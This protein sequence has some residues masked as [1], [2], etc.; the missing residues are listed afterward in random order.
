VQRS[1][2]IRNHFWIGFRAVQLKKV[3]VNTGDPT[4]TNNTHLRQ[5]LV[6][7]WERSNASPVLMDLHYG[8]GQATNDHGLQPG[9]TYSDTAGKTHVTNLG[10]GG[11]SPNEYIDVQVNTGKFLGN[12]APEPLW[13][14]LP[15]SWLVGEPLTMTVMPNDPDGDDVACNWLV[16][17]NS[18]AKNTSSNSVTHTW[19]SAAS[20][21]VKVNV[22]DMKG[23]VTKLSRTITVVNS[24]PVSQWSGTSSNDF[25]NTG[26]NWVAAAEPTSKIDIASWSDAFTGSNQPMISS[27]TPTRL[28][29]QLQLDP[30]L[31]KDVTLTLAET[32]NQLKVYHGGIDMSAADQNLRITGNGSVLLQTSQSWVTSAGTTLAVETDIDLNSK[33]LTVNSDGT[34]VLSCAIAGGQLRKTGSGLL[35]LEA[36]NSNIVNTVVDNGMLALGTASSIGTFSFAENL[37]LNGDLQLTIDPA[38]PQ[39]CD[40]ID[41]AGTLD[42]NGSGTI[43]INNI[44]GTGFTTGQLF[45]VFS[46]PFPGGATM[47]VS[48]AEPAPGFIW[49]NRLG[50]DGTIAVIPA[51]SVGTFDYWTVITS[52]V[53]GPNAGFE[54]DANGDGVKNGLAYF[55]GATTALDDATSLLPVWDYNPSNAAFIVSYPRLDEATNHI[56]SAIEYTTNLTEWILAVDGQDGI[57]ELV[58]DDYYAAGIDRVTVTLADILAPGGQLFGRLVVLDRMSPE[59]VLPHYGAWAKGLGLVGA[60]ADPS[61]D[62]DGDGLTN[63]EEFLGGTNP[64]DPPLP[65]GTVMYLSGLGGGF[66]GIIGDDGARYDPHS[67]LPSNFRVDG[68]RVGFRAR[69]IPGAVCVHMWGS[70]VEVLEIR[71]L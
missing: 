63:V 16:K 31:D 55:L 64:Q 38:A 59:V 39:S 29:H 36:A 47:A 21:S 8:G 42:G 12:R 61:V 13:D 3:N 35:C 56:Y 19:T 11:T 71:E 60:D 62:L 17:P 33:T 2:S 26:S 24:Y 30:S 48:P 49:V 53:F 37:T 14:D 5:S 40:L 15:Y 9:E 50:I 46:Q 34:T 44:G 23:G 22:S 45:Q 7:Y 32:N 69:K 70:I 66:Y 43:Y 25:W 18:I 20:R 10:R 65:S 57:T 1:T 41:V 51:P 68:L 67:S 27:A 4:K 58:E 54:A 52:G 6:F 28:V